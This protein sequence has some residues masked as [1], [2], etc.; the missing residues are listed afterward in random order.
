MKDQTGPK[1][2]RR[3]VLVAAMVLVAG[4]LAMV[5]TSPGPFERGG[6]EAIAPALLTREDLAAVL[7]GEAASYR[8]VPPP[9][10]LA[11]AERQAGRLPFGAVPLPD[12]RLLITWRGPQGRVEVTQGVLYYRDPAAAARLQGM[13]ATLLRHAFD[14]AATP[15][16]L[17]GADGSQAWSAP[18]YE[19]VGFR[20][21]GRLVFV[22]VAAAAPDRVPV[23]LAA[24]AMARLEALEAAETAAAA[25]LDPVAA[26]LEVVTVGPSPGH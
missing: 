22:G 8:R 25:T 20:R 1:V 23:A 4:A 26:P 12:Q 7:G 5:V 13:A 9:I 18:G 2:W 16:D 14:L 19:A 6:T 21:G 3:W 11:E 15:L 10:D 24:R 17:A